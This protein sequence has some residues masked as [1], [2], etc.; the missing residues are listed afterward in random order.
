MLIR[1][2]KTNVVLRYG[3]LH[4][5]LCVLTPGTSCNTLLGLWVGQRRVSSDPGGVQTL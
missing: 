1:A 4:P 5:P 2:G 3:T